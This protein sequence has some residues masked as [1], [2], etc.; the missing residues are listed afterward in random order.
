MESQDRPV[1]ASQPHALALPE[2]EAAKLLGLSVRSLQRKRQEGGGPVYVRLGERRIAYRTA[3]LEGWLASRR[4]ASTS[5][6]TVARRG[7]A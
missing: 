4:V 7:A 2:T 5:A 6:A 3:D 1:Q